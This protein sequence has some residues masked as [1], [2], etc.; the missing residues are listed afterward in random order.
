MRRTTALTLLIAGWLALPA[1]ADFVTVND[2]GNLLFW[3]GSGANQAALVVYF[4]DPVYGD[5]AAPAAVAW[6][7]RWDG[8]K[9]QADMLFAL[10]GSI[11]VVAGTPPAPPVPQSGSDPRLAIDVEYSSYTYLDQTFSAWL[12]TAI[13]Y[14]QVGLPAPWPQTLREMTSQSPPDI[15]PYSFVPASGTAWPAGGVLDLIADTGI[16]DTLLQDRG[17]YGFVAAEYL[18]IPTDPPDFVGFPTTFAFDQPVA[19]VPEPAALV[20]AACGCMALGMWVRRRN[21]R[22]TL[23]VESAKPRGTRNRT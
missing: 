23:S 17:W 16:S 10:A 12:L 11:D 19:A 6:G 5:G 20:L 7:Y 14:D 4:D 13:R 3:S 22:A 8:A 21:G 15:A 2:F 1:R 18:I 9:T